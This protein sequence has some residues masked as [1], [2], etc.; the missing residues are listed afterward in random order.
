MIEGAIYKSNGN[1][2]VYGFDYATVLEVIKEIRKHPQDV[3]GVRDWAS[4]EAHSLVYF[5]NV[6]EKQDSMRRTLM[7]LNGQ[8][9]QELLETEYDLISA[10]KVNEISILKELNQ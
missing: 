6:K 9:Y 1:H 3:D 4:V 7:W 5:W 8:E 10:G 2:E